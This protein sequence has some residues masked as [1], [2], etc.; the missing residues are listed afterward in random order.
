MILGTRLA[1]ICLNAAQ[2]VGGGLA[3]LGEVFLKNVL[4]VF[5][6]G[7]GGMRFAARGLLGWRTHRRNMRS[8]FPMLMTV[9]GYVCVWLMY[10]NAV[11]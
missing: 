2:K 3:V 1:G 7:A 9:A 11:I 5:D 6:V 8:F 10:R 4:A